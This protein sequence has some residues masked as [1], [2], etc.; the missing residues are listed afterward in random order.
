MTRRILLSGA[1]GALVLGTMAVAAVE[2]APPLPVWEQSE[3]ASPLVER[4]QYGERRRERERIR[5]ECAKEPISVTGKQR[6]TYALAR[7]SARRAWE[8]RT[9]FRDGELYIDIRNA[10][11]IRGP[12]SEPEYRCTISSPALRLKR[13]QLIA[14]PCRA[15]RTG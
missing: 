13:C 4:A 3:T 2:A 14:V 10:H 7:A 15:P 5:R 11:G 1:A 12:N 8:E 9:R 6:V